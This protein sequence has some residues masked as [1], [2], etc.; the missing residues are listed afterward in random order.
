MEKLR[1]SAPGFLFI[2]ILLGL[3]IM[4]GASAQPLISPW[5]EKLL[6]AP[7]PEAASLEDL[8]A[9]GPARN[10][11]ETQAESLA[12]LMARLQASPNDADTLV[13]I[14]EIFMEAEEWSR[15]EFFLGKAV[16][17]RPGDPRPFY[18]LGLTQY[19]D[20]KMD[21]AAASFEYLLA[22]KEDPAAM[23]NLAVIYKYHLNKE[24]QAQDLLR[25]VLESASADLDTL[26]RARKE[27]E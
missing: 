16:L 25:R 8:P 12:Q 26:D 19:Q 6:L 23:Y 22:I 7:A 27:L 20:G 21:L 18:L 3:L 13:R 5:M 24:Q 2:F 4:L 17:S 15:A 14:G 1:P 11:S 9:S 10:L